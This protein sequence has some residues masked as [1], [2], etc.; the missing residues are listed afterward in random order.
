MELKFKKLKPEAVIPNY[1]HDD[2]MGF[3]LYSCEDCILQPGEKH[4]FNIGIASEIQ[5][6]YGVLIKDKG[7]IGTLGVHVLAGVLDA[8]YRGEWMVVLVN[9]SKEPFEIKAGNKIAQGIHLQVEQPTIIET[10]DE[11]SETERGAGGWGST[12]K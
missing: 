2:D 3:D 10:T 1:A 7:R 8:G 12:G 6:G 5:K 11:L 9:F 4:S